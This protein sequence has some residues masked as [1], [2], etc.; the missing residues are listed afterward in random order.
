MQAKR[1]LKLFAWHAGIFVVVP[2]FVFT[3]VLAYGLHR[4]FLFFAYCYPAYLIFP[5]RYRAHA[6]IV[7][8]DAVAWALL[9]LFWLLVAVVSSLLHA[10]LTRHRIAQPGAAP[11]GG[12]AASAGNS[13]ILIGPPSVS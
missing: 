6:A 9:V 3:G 13:N 10:F 1:T 2:Q 4:P 11:S 12:P 7:P 5:D 8:E